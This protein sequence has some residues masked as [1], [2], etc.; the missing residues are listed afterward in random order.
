MIGPGPHCLAQLVLGL[1]PLGES[2]MSKAAFDQIVGQVETL[3]VAGD[4]IGSF[5]GCVLPGLA[6]RAGPLTAASL[7]AAV[8]NACQIV[9]AHPHAATARNSPTVKSGVLCRRA[10]RRN[11]YA[12]EGG[13]AWTGSFLMYR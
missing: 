6:R 12:S 1:G 10:E 2:G 11:L 8:W 7:A 5:F 9:M 13:Q 3:E 4:G